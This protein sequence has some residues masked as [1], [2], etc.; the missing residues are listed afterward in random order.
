M[1]KILL[2]ITGLVITAMGYGQNHSPIAIEKSE[3]IAVTLPIKPGSPQQV[4]VTLPIK[5]GSPDRCS[6]PTGV[7]SKSLLPC[8]LSRRGV[9]PEVSTA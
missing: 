2:A 9:L 6:L 8:Q 1:R 7:P 4:A 3:Q 5:P